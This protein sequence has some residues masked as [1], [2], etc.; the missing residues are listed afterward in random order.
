M[1]ADLETLRKIIDDIRHSVT[2]LK[3]LDP[4]VQDIAR[5]VYFEALRYTFLTSTG[6]AA[7]AFF[8]AFFTKGKRLDRK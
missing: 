4:E 6:W 7:V 3:D 1:F 8:V 2:V 5:R